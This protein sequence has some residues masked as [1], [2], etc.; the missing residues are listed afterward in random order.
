MLGTPTGRKISE[1]AR[2]LERRPFDC[3]AGL[4]ML[5]PGWPQYFWGQ[6]Q[7]G[8]VLAGLFSTALAMG[9]WSWGTW[10]GWGLFAVA[11]V[12]HV[13][14]VVDSLRQAS[15]PVYRSRAGL[16]L[17]TA[18][19]ALVFYLPP[20]L[21]LSIVAW[22]GI[23]SGAGRG[24][25]VNCWAYRDAKPQRGDWIWMRL[26]FG[27]PRSALV[28]AVAG[29]DVEWTG[30]T[31]RVDGRDGPLHG[32]LRLNAWPQACRFRVPPSQFL[33]EPEDLGVSSPPTGPLVLVTPEEII[34]R[35]WARIY[36]VW[37]RRLL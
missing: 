23:S 8:W 35:A 3:P 31:W 27:E 18:A 34:G 28:L 25:L 9:F 15:F 1:G 32:P 20:W 21:I 30:R 16:P 10:V 22:P 12:T 11:F 7:R 5:F 19:L 6:R 13:A 37:E 2:L 33:V 36:P 17:A 26:P 14:S 4:R 24:Y 29:Q